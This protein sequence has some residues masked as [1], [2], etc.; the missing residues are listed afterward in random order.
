MFN[1]FDFIT[2]KGAAKIG[3]KMLDRDELELMKYSSYEPNA[4]D[5]MFFKISRFM[6]WMAGLLFIA[7]F[8]PGL[9]LELTSDG[10]KS[11]MNM[12][13][14]CIVLLAYLITLPGLAGSVYLCKLTGSKLLKID[15]GLRL[16]IVSVLLFIMTTATIKLYTANH[17]LGLF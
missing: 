6:F 3:V 17:F 16:I 5:K 14:L 10:I 1:F 2:W 13:T 9:L 15:I 11:G 4:V 8:I 12:K 7:H